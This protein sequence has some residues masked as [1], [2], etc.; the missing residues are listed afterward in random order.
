[1]QNFQSTS[2]SQHSGAYPQSHHAPPPSRNHGEA[3]LCSRPAQRGARQPALHHVGDPTR[4]C[5]NEHSRRGKTQ[6]HE[7]HHLP[8]HNRKYFLNISEVQR[9]DA[10]QP[11]YLGQT[12][13]SG[14]LEYMTMEGGIQVVEGCCSDMAITLNVLTPKKMIVM[15]YGVHRLRAFGH[16]LKD[17]L[18][19]LHP[20][21]SEND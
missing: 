11:F 13:T 5:A 10:S 7:Y 16:Y 3:A 12:I 1:A 4:G 8:P 14:D 2:N 19:F 21:G 9:M 6:N 20:N 15:M 17:T 18:V